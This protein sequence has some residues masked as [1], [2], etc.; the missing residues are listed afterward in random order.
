MKNKRGFTLIELIAV[1]IILGVL[2]VIAIPTITKYTSGARESTYKSHEVSMAE[3]ARAYTID[4][5]NSNENGCTVPREKETI[6]VYLDKLIEEEY[7]SKL[8]DPKNQGTFCSSEKSFVKVKKTGKSNFE[9]E[10]CL[11]CGGYSTPNEIC[12]NYEGD[13]DFPVCGDVSGVSS[14]WTRVPR[15][16]SVGCTDQSSGCAQDRFSRTFSESTNLGEITIVDRSGRT[17]RCSVQARVDVTAPTCKIVD[18]PANKSLP[19]MIDIADEHSG[20]ATYGMGVSANTPDY[21]KKDSFKLG[22]QTTRVY[23]YVK[24][25]AGN[26]GMCSKTIVV[27]GLFKI[28]YDPNGGTGTMADTECFS[29]ENCTVSPN[30]F[31][32]PNARFKY[33]TTSKNGTGI[34]IHNNETRALTVIGDKL[35]LY[36]QWDEPEYVHDG[37]ITFTGT[38]FVNTGMFLFSSDNYQR[39]F[40]MKVKVEDV[41]S[42]T[43]AQSV[44]IGDIDEKGEPYYGTVV[45]TNGT[46]A[47]KLVLTSNSHSSSS[48]PTVNYAKNMQIVI[49]RVQNRLYYS[50][51]GGA[52]F[53]YGANYTGFTNTF[54][55]PSTVGARIWSNGKENY[56]DLDRFFKGTL[57]NISIKYLINERVLT[58]N[59]NGGTVCDPDTVT[60]HDMAAWGTLCTTTRTGYTFKEWNTKQDGSGT[61]ITSTTIA[62]SSYP[63]YAKWKGN[64][65]AVTFDRQGG[66]GGTA[67]VTATYDSPMPTATAPTRT[68]YTFGGYYTGTNGSGTQYYKADMTSARNWDKTSVTTLYAKWTANTYKISFSANGGSGGQTANVT[69]TYAANM[70]T[71]STT[72]P[73]RTGY[74]FGGWYDT[75]AATGGTQYYTAAGASAR[76]W[77]KTANTTLYA[78]WTANTYTVTLNQQSGS[79]GTTSVTATY[80]SPMPSAT[81]STRTGYTFGGYYTGTNGSGTQ[82]YKADMTSARNWDKT[83]VT[84]LYAKWT[85]NTY[86]ISFSANGGSGGQTA[87]VTATY[88]ANMPTISTTKPTRTG[89]TFGGWYDTSAATGGTQYYT[90]AGASARTWNKTANTTLYANWTINQNTIVV[91]ANS[92]IGGQ[93]SEKNYGSTTSVSVS[94]SGYKFTGW[95][96]SGTCGTIGSNAN[97]TYTHPSNNGTTCTITANWQANKDPGFSVSTGTITVSPGINVKCKK[98]SACHASASVSNGVKYFNV[99]NAVE[100]TYS[101]SSEPS[102]LSAYTAASHWYAGGTSAAGTHQVTVTQTYGIGSATRVATLHIT[103]TPKDPSYATVTKN[104]TVNVVYCTTDAIENDGGCSMLAPHSTTCHTYMCWDTRGNAN[105]GVCTCD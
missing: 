55:V 30:T 98:T 71:I 75:S 29:N 49:K 100:G 57:S 88:A 79:G 17:T 36:A 18:N 77:N 41:K 8:Q 99:S 7:I 26:E 31:T 80:D 73:T 38:N 70:P 32:K 67:S 61:P 44:L 76:T 23:G 21:N 85:A 56:F 64:I 81:A 43:S 27:F 59:S 82:Y 19:K 89:Y 68:G 5:L 96:Q 66:T 65:Y 51:D 78:R 74:T 12:T 42:D 6:N 48:T 83:S 4:C 50:S 84:T 90:A 63:V 15:T 22:N 9:Y 93:T 47:T 92:G 10:T 95:T 20:V 102:I 25:Q 103:F 2:L 46:D 37:A 69:A 34:I 104:V 86:K 40:E 3:A 14:A 97:F 16:I 87:N 105:W 24:D 39:D 101:F 62:T 28:K 91:N 94:R 45:K 58:F 60:T 54:D 52:S 53:K 13:E 33:W 1:I 11:F 35:I 72:K